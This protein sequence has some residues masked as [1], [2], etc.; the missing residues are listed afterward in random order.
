MSPEF[1]PERLKK[2]IVKIGSV[3]LI[4]QGNEVLK[5]GRFQRI[6]GLKTMIIKEG[7]LHINGTNL[8]HFQAVLETNNIVSFFLATIQGPKLAVSWI[9]YQTSEP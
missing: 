9:Q 1:F 2:T 4:L 8:Y 6:L 5:N 3:K 7:Y